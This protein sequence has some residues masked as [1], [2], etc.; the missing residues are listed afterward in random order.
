MPNTSGEVRPVC[1]FIYAKK[2]YEYVEEQNFEKCSVFDAE[3][4]G[5]LKSGI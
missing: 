2:G 5:K 4:S 3:D 1:Y